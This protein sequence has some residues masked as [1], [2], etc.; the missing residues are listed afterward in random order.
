MDLVFFKDAMTH[1]VKVI[2]FLL[3]FYQKRGTYRARNALF[4]NLETGRSLCHWI[5]V[6]K[7]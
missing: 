4:E 1:L 2:S 6:A 7:A 5:C 3:G